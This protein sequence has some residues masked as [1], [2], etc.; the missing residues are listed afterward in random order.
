MARKEVDFNGTYILGHIRCDSSFDS[1]ARIENV[2]DL[3]GS[4]NYLSGCLLG[5]P[6]G[7]L[8]Y[9]E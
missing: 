1:H 8:F 6:F 9:P 3:I 4:P 7:F 5:K 2:S